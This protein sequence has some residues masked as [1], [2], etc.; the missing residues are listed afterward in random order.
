VPDLRRRLKVLDKKL[1]DL[2]VMM[3]T[4]LDGLLAGVVVCPDLSSA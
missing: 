4:E 1:M 2:E 3:L